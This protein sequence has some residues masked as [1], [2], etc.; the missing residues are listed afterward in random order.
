[1]RN[2]PSKMSAE[3]LATF[4]HIPDTEIERDMSETAQEIVDLTQTLAG[5]ELIAKYHALLSVRQQAKFCAMEAVEGIADRKAFVDYLELIQ[6]ARRNK[7]QRITPDPDCRD[8]HGEGYFWEDVCGDG[9][10]RMQVV[11][12][13][14]DIGDDETPTKTEE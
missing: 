2:Y 5:W 4:I 8:C 11:C 14:S 7:R 12:D 6:Q 10:Q 13:C 9:G 3:L 1:M